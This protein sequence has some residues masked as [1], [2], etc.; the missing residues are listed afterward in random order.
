LSQ[1]QPTHITSFNNNLRES[2]IKQ[3]KRFVSKDIFI[4]SISKSGFT[5][6]NLLI[7]A[8]ISD[9]TIKSLRLNK[10]GAD[11]LISIPESV[12]AIMKKY[13]LS[14]DEAKLKLRD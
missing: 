8:D 4:E 7:K 14:Q 9:K 6:D 12:I 10:N 3:N 1:L 2:E 13:K 11:R 5:L